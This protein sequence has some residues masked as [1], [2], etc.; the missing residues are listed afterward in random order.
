MEEYLVY[1]ESNP[2]DPNILNSSLLYLCAYINSSRRYSPMTMLNKLSR[3]N[4]KCCQL[5][6]KRMELCKQLREKYLRPL[7][8]SIQK[9]LIGHPFEYSGHCFK[10]IPIPQISAWDYGI[11]ILD[12]DP[13][14]FDKD[15]LSEYRVALTNISFLT[16]KPEACMCFLDVAGCNIINIGITPSDYKYLG[17][18]DPDKLRKLE[19]HLAYD[20][21]YGYK[22]PGR[23]V[24]NLKLPLKYNPITLGAPFP[25]TYQVT[26]GLSRM[27]DPISGIIGRDFDFIIDNF[28]HAIVSFNTLHVDSHD[29]SKYGFMYNGETN[30]AK[31]ASFI[32]PLSD[33]CDHLIDQT[34]AGP[35]NLNT[36]IDYPDVQEFLSSL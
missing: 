9:K 31:T 6:E 17:D 18:I 12:S 26:M 27:F 10:I 20:D 29:W 13:V 2:I 5:L 25:D 14:I 23:Y 11:C 8:L 35:E 3:L 30:Q 34:D 24:L 28:T 16:I 15:F 36:Q 32:R 7:G 1:N 19:E 4:V 22:S 21:I 33:A